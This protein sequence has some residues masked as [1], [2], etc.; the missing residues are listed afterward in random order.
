MLATGWKPYDATRLGHLG[1][2]ASPDVIT[3]VE[4]EQMVGHGADRRGPRT[5]RPSTSVLFV[6]CAGSRDKDH[7]PYCSSVC[8]MA[9]LKHAAYVH[10]QNPDAKVYIVYKDMRT[11]GQYERFYRTAQDHPLNFLTK[12]EVAGVEQAAGRQAG[13]DA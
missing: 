3:N 7:L 6:Q 1:Y 10:E 4:F 2:G 13:G 9:T 11:P 8:C 12:G 5:A